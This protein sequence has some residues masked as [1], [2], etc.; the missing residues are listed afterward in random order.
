MMLFLLQSGVELNLSTIPY[1]NLI[2]VI[3]AVLL[4]LGIILFVLVKYVKKIG[5]VDLNK[6]HKGQTEVYYMNAE[7]DEHDAQLRLKIR[8]ITSSMKTRINNIFYAFRTCPVV[9]IALSNSVRMPLYNSASNNHFTTVLVPEKRESYID[10]LLRS[11]QDEY[12][13]ISGS[14]IGINCIKENTLP[15]WDGTD[16]SMKTMIKQFLYE[17]VND[18][19]TEVIK[20]CLKKIEVY[21]K[22]LPE[23]KNDEFRTGFVNACITKNKNYISLLDR[24][25]R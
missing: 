3:I 20:T 19:V 21:E 2:T 1:I 14:I 13:A 9:V 4:L 17:W 6:E 24:H 25:G 7:N 16:D 22:Y 18:V 8:L 5:P 10:G 23:F 11:I 15:A 12:V